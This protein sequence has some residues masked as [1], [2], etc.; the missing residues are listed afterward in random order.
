FSALGYTVVWMTRYGEELPRLARVLE[1]RTIVLA[2]GATRSDRGDGGDGSEDGDAI[3]A[4]RQL[5]AERA[6]DAVPILILADSVETVDGYRAEIA[7]LTAEVWIKPV[8][9]RALVEFVA[10]PPRTAWRDG[11]V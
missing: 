6:L 8:S 11:V 7:S 10:E 4:L 1:P 9:D 5:R 2:L 3:I